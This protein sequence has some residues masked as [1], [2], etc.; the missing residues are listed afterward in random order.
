[1]TDYGETGAVPVDDAAVADPPTVDEVQ[2]R[3][4]EKYPDQARTAMHHAPPT[5]EELAAIEAGGNP[6]EDPDDLLIE[7]PNS[8]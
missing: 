7:G 5:A 3:Q 2:K 6:V 4:A 1:M 8:A